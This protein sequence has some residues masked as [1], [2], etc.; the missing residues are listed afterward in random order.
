MLT[1]GYIGLALSA[2][3]SA[4][5]LPL[6]SEGVLTGLLLADYNP[7]VCLLVASAANSIGGI[8]NYYIGKL[9]N[10]NWLEK[11]GVKAER[12]EKMEHRIQSYGSWCG[13]L[14]W[15][16]II[17]DPLTIAMG[18]FRAP[19]LPSIILITLGKTIRYA[20]LIFLLV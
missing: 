4:T 9:G 12:L 11:L 16:P 6:A 19:I 8:T 7:L 17:G 15:V 3:L 2:F 1:S 14:S 5:I 10:P 20:I 13:L 18:F